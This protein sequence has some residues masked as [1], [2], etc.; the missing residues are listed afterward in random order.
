[1]KAITIVV[2][3]GLM[4]VLPLVAEN[5]NGFEN[6]VLSR[7]DGTSSQP[8]AIADFSSRTHTEVGTVLSYFSSKKPTPLILR[9]R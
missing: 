6:F 8:V 2:T 7:D 1:M 4:L 5:V 9:I 3:A